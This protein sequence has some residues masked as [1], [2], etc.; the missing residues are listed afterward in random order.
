MPLRPGDLLC[1]PDRAAV[2]VHQTT[3]RR[4]MRKDH[5]PAAPIAGWVWPG[6]RRRIAHA[7]LLRQGEG[8]ATL[9][10]VGVAAAPRQGGLERGELL[11]EVSPLWSR[12]ARCRW[13]CRWLA[14]GCRCRALALCP[15]LAGHGSPEGSLALLLLAPPLTRLFEIA[16]DAA[17][18]KQTK[19][20][21]GFLRL[22]VS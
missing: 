1:S 2:E 7:A 19:R 4:G 12:V 22:N 5:A 8:N 17:H 16:P 14:G 20:P 10:Q 6:A 9:L 15:L 3:V 11:G 13:A 21:D 18:A